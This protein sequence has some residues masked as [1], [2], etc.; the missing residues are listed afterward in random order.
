MQ[1]A[2]WYRSS[3]PEDEE[4]E[5]DT[6]MESLLETQ[7]SWNPFSIFGSSLPCVE[8]EDVFDYEVRATIGR[9]RSRAFAISSS[10][11]LD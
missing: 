2:N 7:D 5:K 11:I 8:L 6:L 3:S 1:K 10:S 9:D 4:E